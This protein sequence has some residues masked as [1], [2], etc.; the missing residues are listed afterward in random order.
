[1]DLFLV[2][3][4][5]GLRE[6]YHC[7]DV[8]NCNSLQLSVQKFFKLPPTKDE[9]KRGELRFVPFDYKQYCDKM[10]PLPDAISCAATVYL[11]QLCDNM[12][13]PDSNDEV[14]KRIFKER[15]FARLCSLLVFLFKVANSSS[16][17]DDTL[18]IRQNALLAP[19]CFLPL[20]SVVC[21]KILNAEHNKNQKF[22]C[23]TDQSDTRVSRPFHSLVGYIASIPSRS[24]ANPSKDGD[25]S[26]TDRE[27]LWNR[28]LPSVTDPNQ[29]QLFS[30]LP[31][32]DKRLDCAEG[33]Y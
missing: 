15:S 19:L 11:K 16:K 4:C 25:D 23:H 33:R 6:A 12:L 31:P 24:Q 26:E 8:D 20:V 1:M 10:M 18:Q 13:K 9:P 27:N 3:F 32:A 30:K 7:V 5:T 17:D 2:C 14:E 29:L 21:H 28:F 22:L